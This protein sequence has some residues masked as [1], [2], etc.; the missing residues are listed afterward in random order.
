MLLST[1]N[2]L[3]GF[4]V[5]LN[6]SACEDIDSIYP[7][8]RFSSAT[9]YRRDDIDLALKRAFPWVL[10][11]MNSDGGFVFRRNESFCYG[12]EEMYSGYNES[13][14]FATWFRTLCLA[15]LINYLELSNQFKIQ[16]IPGLECGNGI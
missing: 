11:N 4:G 10:A 12:H 9:N 16:N 13:S 2:V 15:Y 5:T 14:M 8:I 1:Q 7:L 6:S 3:G